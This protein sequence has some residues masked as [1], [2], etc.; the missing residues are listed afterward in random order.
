MLEELAQM[1]AP[2]I[3]FHIR[4]G[5]KLTEDVQL[6][7]MPGLLITMWTFLTAGILNASAYECKM[8]LLNEH[9]ATSVH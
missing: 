1:P 7:S 8:W 5:D 4:G 2:R 6:V 3:G 9:G